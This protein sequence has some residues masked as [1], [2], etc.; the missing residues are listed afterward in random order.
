MANI[1]GKNPNRSRPIFKAIM[2]VVLLVVIGLAGAFTPVA[3]GY[4]NQQQQQAREN[5]M[6]AERTEI[7]DLRVFG[8]PDE[9]NQ[10][11]DEALKDTSL[12]TEEKYRLYIEQGNIPFDKQDYVAAAVIYEKAKALSDTY[13]INELLAITYRSAGNNEKAVEAYKRA[14]QLIPEDLPTRD[15]RKASLEEYIRMLGGTP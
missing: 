12:T 11:I 4:F 5:E 2:I 8:K 9:A 13:E 15:S 10:K 6:N 3:I 14:I 7:Q 1:L